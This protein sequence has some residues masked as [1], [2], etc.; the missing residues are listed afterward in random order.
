MTER[1]IESPYGAGRPKEGSGAAGPMHRCE[2]L[3]PRDIDNRKGGV[4]EPIMSRR[5]QQTASGITGGMQ[6]ASGV[7]RGACD[8][9]PARDRRDP[10]WR[11]TLGEGGAYKPSAKGSRA[12]R[13]S[14]RPIVPMRAGTKTPSEGRGLALV[15]PATEGKREGMTRETGPN[16]P[17]GRKSSAK[18]RKLQRRLYMTAKRSPGRRFHALHDQIFRGDVLAEAWKRVRSNG[19]AA[20]VDGETLKDIERQGV[21]GFLNGIQKRLKEGRYRPQLVRRRY[22]AKADG[23]PRPLGIPTVRDRVVQMAAKIVLEPIFE[24]GFKGSS[25]GFRPKKDAT[26]ALEAIRLVGGRGQRYVVDGDIRNFFGE[27]DHGILMKRLARRISDQKVL[28]LLRQ[29]LKAGIMEEG[30]V[31]ASTLGTPQGGVISPLLANV[32]LDFLDGVWER[33]CKRLGLLVRYADDFVVLC[34]TRKA[35]EEALRRLGIVLGRL[36]LRLHPDKTRIVEIGLGKG[37]FDF[38]GCHL[39][40]VQSHFKRRTYLFRWPGRRAMKHIQ[41]RVRGLT[42]RRRR[43]GVEGIR[44][45]IADLNP[46]LRGWGNYFQ[47]GNASLKFRQV[48]RLVEKRL[49]RLI[50]RRGGYGRITGTPEEWTH[51]RFVK[52]HGLHKLLGTIRYPAGVKAA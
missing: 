47:T 8:E 46:V 50:L 17:G 13:E 41:S 42:D 40:I 10:T 4:A 39:R 38:L 48:D 26:Q 27:I 49:K 25:Y 35:A 33:Q 9:G 52:E 7:R 21:E 18:V 12:G 20:G 3:Q 14:E 1:G 37:G 51:E 45:V 32:T 6:D 34:R 2:L 24:A 36:R 23:K 5:R 15:V 30:V 28:K 44:E 31:K 22:I 16:H 29:W 19:G 43:A 11:P